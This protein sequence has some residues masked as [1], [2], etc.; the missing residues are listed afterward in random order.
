M[1][2]N[3]SDLKELYLIRFKDARDFIKDRLIAAKNSLD[4]LR[5][6]L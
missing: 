2:Y 6:Y 4:E 1:N 3:F 5:G